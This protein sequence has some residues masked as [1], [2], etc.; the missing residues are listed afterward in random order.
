M[1]DEL[2]RFERAS[3]LGLQENEK[4]WTA[5]LRHGLWKP[6]RGDWLLLGY[7]PN[8]GC[9]CLTCLDSP[10]W[11]VIETVIPFQNLAELEFT[12]GFLATCSRHRGMAMAPVYKN[13]PILA[14]RRWCRYSDGKCLDCGKEE[15]RGQSPEL[16]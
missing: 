3:T 7:A 5:M 15:E 13:R 9:W 16:P 10:I 1:D 4:Y 11:A 2:R 6:E 12:H 8:Q 14:V